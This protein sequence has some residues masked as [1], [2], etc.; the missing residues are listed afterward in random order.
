MS[1]RVPSTPEQESKERSEFLVEA[2]EQHEK[3][4][5]DLERGAENAHEQDE[6]K[7]KEAV[8]KALAN[9][10][11]KETAAP[12]EK[13][14]KKRTPKRT[15]KT[16][17]VSFKKEMSNAQSHMSTPSRAFSKL[18]HAKPVEKASEAVGAT[19]ARPNAL[20]AGSITAFLLTSGLYF[21]AKHVG[22]PLSGFE[23]IGA[24]IIGW[25][26]GIIFDFA[27]IMITGKST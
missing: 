13:L 26:V 21:W 27:R 10:Q 8:E 17:D 2:H 3:L 25:L 20:L 6:D 24:F 16:L 14:E 18:I 22:Y 4:R 9:K 19:V 5:E 23:T 1:E 12:A 15:K 7:A 11:E